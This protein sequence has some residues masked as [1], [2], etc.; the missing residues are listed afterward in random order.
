MELDPK[1]R[2]QSMREWLD[3]LG[4]SGETS[5]T[6]TPTPPKPEPKINCIAVSAIA[7]PTLPL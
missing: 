2:S 4:L 6:E 7:I 3:L 1:K 5:T